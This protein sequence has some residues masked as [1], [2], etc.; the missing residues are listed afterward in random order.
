MQTIK[1][2]QSLS[3]LP[4]QLYTADQLRAIDASVIAA[5]TPGTQLMLRA[6]RAA[7]SCLQSNWPNVS[8]LWVFCGSGNNGGDG[9][10]VA[11]LAAQRGMAVT[12]VELANPDRQSADAAAARAQL[13]SCGVEPIALADLDQLQWKQASSKTAC[14][15]DA[16][17]GTG[18]SGEPRADYKNAIGLINQST[19][20]VLAL[21]IPSGVC[22]DTGHVTNECAVCADHTVSFI[23]L[24]RGL[25]TADAVSFI[26][27]LIYSDLDSGSDIGASA[28]AQRPAAQLLKLEMLKRQLPAR[29]ATAYKNQ[30]GHVLVVGGDSGMAGAALLSASAALR[31]GAGLV[32][33]ATRRAHVAAFI[34]RQPE[35]MAHG[36]EQ[37]SELKPL[38]ERARVVVLGPGLG[39][40]DWSEQMLRL[41][42]TYAEQKLLPV[43]ID[44]DALNGIAAQPSLLPHTIQAVLT[45]HVGEAR[46]LLGGPD[47]TTSNNR[48][49][50][51]DA[52]RQRYQ[53][54][55]VLKGAGTL[56]AGDT[57]VALNPY[58]GAALATAGTGDV[59]SGVIAALM[60]QGLGREQAAQAGVVAHAAAADLWRADH[61]AN[62]MVAS[63]LL[64]LL[65]ALFNHLAASSSI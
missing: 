51:L 37:G 9:F 19:L 60:A 28:E 26:G 2:W 7:F 32:S 29:L 24:K 16:L 21:D 27:E 45:P 64:Q 50:L 31:C 35:L 13:L 57:G 48:F 11:M 34:A 25:F 41:C 53:Q 14:I 54:V 5:G 3:A 33:V 46:R 1:K 47:E 15:V 61:G 40:S 30:S 44:A 23:G 65:P 4:A 20:P 59:L 39:K 17:L 36:I 18:L 8:T 38:L 49:A 55:T 63:D 6:A 56:V 42:L 12:V 58:G 62:G 52:L 10:L 43:V 22:S